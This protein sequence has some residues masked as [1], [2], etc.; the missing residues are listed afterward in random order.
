MR[1]RFSLEPGVPLQNH[2][3]ALQTEEGRPIYR[4]LKHAVVCPKHCLGTLP[5]EKHR[6]E[7]QD[8]ANPGLGRGNVWLAHPG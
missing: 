1:K 8:G 4:E 3:N 5:W 2:V 6:M 7:L